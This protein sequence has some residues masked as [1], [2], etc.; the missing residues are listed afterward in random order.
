MSM[1][2]TERKLW[3]SLTPAEQKT[4]IEEICKNSG[5]CAITTNPKVQLIA[6]G[7]AAL[8]PDP[9]T[10]TIAMGVTAVGAA[11]GAFLPADLPTPAPIP[12]PPTLLT[13]LT[14]LKPSKPVLPAGTIAA[15]DPKRGGYRVAVPRGLS[16]FGAAAAFTEVGVQSS[17]PAGA[18]LVALK[19]FDQETGTAKPWFKNPLVLGGI[20]AGVV[21]AGV[22]GY[23][24]LRR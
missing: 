1:S 18:R 12:K 13:K 5:I 20:G 6:T 17:P 24:V 19:T 2:A 21:A 11:C 4:V 22:G 10:K 16:G 7:T 3:E 8:S 15:F 9:T 14:A 23:F